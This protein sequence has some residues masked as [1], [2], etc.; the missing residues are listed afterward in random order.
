M[1]KVIEIFNLIWNSITETFSEN[2]VASKTNILDKYFI[3]YNDWKFLTVEFSEKDILVLSAHFHHF[4]PY[5]YWV[6]PLKQLT[7][8]R[9]LSIRQN[10]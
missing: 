5:F 10:T 9:R 8:Y 3:C 7:I 2:V 6:K 4:I 1:K